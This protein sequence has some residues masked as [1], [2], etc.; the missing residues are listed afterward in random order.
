MGHPTDSRRK[1]LQLGFAMPAEW[2]RHE[3]TWLSWP[4]DPITWPDR[5]PQVEEVFLHM[6]ALLAAN[7]R[8]DLLVDDVATEQ[9]VKDR[10]A[11]L[12][13]HQGEVRYH[14]I[15]TADSWIRDYGPNFLLRESDG[16]LAL[17]DWIFNAWGN[18]Y[19][20]LKRDSGIPE[21]VAGL[22]QLERF[23]PGIVLEGGSIDVNGQ[24]TCL[25]TEQCLLNRN[26]NPHL[27]KEEIERHLCDHLGVNQVVWLGEGIVGDD[28]DG[29]IDDIARFVAPDTIVCAREDD[30][31]DPNYGLLEDNLE[32]LKKTRDS[33]GKAFRIVPLPMPGPIQGTEGRL[34]ASYANFYIANG[35]VLVPT[36]GHGNDAQALKILSEL[37][38]DRKVT[39][40]HC[41]PLVWGLGTLHCVTQQQPA[42][43]E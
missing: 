5:V 35:L 17:N 16:Q 23:I 3:A 37:F 39:G 21:V 26:R 43:G 18:K 7:E 30:P 11:G 28:T 4:K 38:P 22:L 1:P 29:H 32:R 42:G 2:R 10:L 19:E 41:E 24:G 27:S 15:P 13:A 25:T 20:E 6:I 31:A 34:P 36:F 12:S 40:I 8:V 33:N 9:T 14:L